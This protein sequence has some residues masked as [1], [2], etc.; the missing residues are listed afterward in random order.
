M[1]A[2]ITLTLPWEA[3]AEHRSAGRAFLAFFAW[4]WF[5]VIAKG[6]ERQQQGM[7]GLS[8]WGLSVRACS[9]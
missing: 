8:T 2:K 5:P 9:P 3:C 6:P 7:P 4:T 1:V